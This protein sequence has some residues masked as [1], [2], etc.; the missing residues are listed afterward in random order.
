MLIHHRIE[1]ERR[2]WVMNCA[3]VGEQ[4]R[5]RKTE[6]AKNIVLKF[7]DVMTTLCET[8]KNNSIISVDFSFLLR[9]DVSQVE[10]QFSCQWQQIKF[11]LSTFKIIFAWNCVEKFSCWKQK[12]VEEYKIL[13][14]MVGIL[15]CCAVVYS[16]SRTRKNL[17][18]TTS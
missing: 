5:E 17:S 8:R 9:F 6:Q 18:L 12:T 11:Y 2:V 10:V 1:H 3:A 14:S 7:S 4:E 15:F 13:Q 16:Y